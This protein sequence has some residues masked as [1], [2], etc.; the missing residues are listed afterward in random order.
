M[1]Q[2]S[3]VLKEHAI[4]ML[5]AGMSTRAVARELNVHFSTISRLQRCFKEF[6]STSNRPHNR[7]SRIT[8]PAQDLHIQHLHL[9]DHLSPATRT[10]AATISLHNQKTSAQTVR[11]RLKEAHLHARRPHQGLDLTAVRRHNRPEWVNAHIWWRLTLWR[12]ALFM[13]ESRFSLYRADGRQ[14]VWRRVGE[15]FADVNVVNRVAHGG[16][17]VG[18]C[19]GQRTQVHFIDSILNAQRYRDEI[20]RPIV[21]PFIHDHHLMLQHDN[22]QPHVARICTQFL[23][24]EKIPVPVHGQHTHRTLSMFG[25]LWIGVYDSVFQFLPISSNFVQPLKRSGPTVHRPQST[26]WS[27]LCEGDVVHCVKQMLVTPD[28]DWFSDTPNT[29][30]LQLLI[31]EWP[32]IVASLRHTCPITILSN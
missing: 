10:A 9:Q 16:G 2:M 31:L 11:N 24:A 12:S 18:V 29:L 15:W 30:K 28:T 1:P 13:E 17:G 25:M 26:T 8:T 6:G 21:V 3:Q 14:R 20:L 32:F 4:S 23:E 19:Y 7:R 22:A 27:T 5:T